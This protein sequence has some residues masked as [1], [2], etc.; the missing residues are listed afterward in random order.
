[1]Q[2][3]CISHCVCPTGFSP[4]KIQDRNVKKK[5]CHFSEIYFWFLKAE[6]SERPVPYNDLMVPNRIYTATLYYSA[7]KTPLEQHLIPALHITYHRFN[8]NVPRV[9]EL[10]FTNPVQA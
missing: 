6:V 5:P 9:K 8:L 2:T 7:P 3:D 4:T 1:M 10:T